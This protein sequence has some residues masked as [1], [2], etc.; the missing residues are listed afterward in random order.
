MIFANAKPQYASVT[1]WERFVSET[2]AHPPS[3]LDHDVSIP[4]WAAQS[5]PSGETGFATTYA[6]VAPAGYGDDMRTAKAQLDAIGDNSLRP[7]PITDPVPTAALSAIE[8]GSASGLADDIAQVAGGFIRGRS[9]TGLLG[10]SRIG[11]VLIGNK[12][13]NPTAALDCREFSWDAP[14][15]GMIGLR[16]SGSACPAHTITA[17]VDMVTRALAY[18]ADGRPVATTMLQANPLFDMSVH[19]HPT[20]VDRPIGADA[21]QIDTLIDTYYRSER[22]VSIVDFLPYLADQVATTNDV[23]IY[24]SA[25]VFMLA[26]W[27]H[28][29][30]DSDKQEHSQVGQTVSDI[31]RSLQED[32]PIEKTVGDA[33]NEEKSRSPGSAR[34]ALL[35]GKPAYFDDRVTTIARGCLNSKDLDAYFDCVGQAFDN[36]DDE[37]KTNISNDRSVNWRLESGVREA[38]YTVADGASISDDIALHGSSI[39]PFEFEIHVAFGSAPQFARSASDA[40]AQ[41]HKF[42][43]CFQS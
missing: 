20:L 18:A 6:D 13:K 32:A 24:H 11:G 29:A 38:P 4:Q 25:L 42:L 15:N 41:E 19:L 14:K 30:S 2:A 1:H 27:W 35:A 40:L 16:F 26:D 17:P 10:F 5:P 12:P 9:Y 22:P 36:L 39:G 34:L 23:I 3:A 8:N 37:T 43:F 7:P 33:L 21:I 28:G 31:E